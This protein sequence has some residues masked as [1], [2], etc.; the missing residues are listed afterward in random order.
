M[1]AYIIKDDESFWPM[2]KSLYHK[3]MPILMSWVWKETDAYAYITSTFR[4]DKVGEKPSVHGT[5]PCRGLDLRSWDLV[6]GIPEKIRDHVNSEWIYDP[7][8]P[9]KMVCK[10][11]K[12]HLHFQVHDN[13]RMRTDREK[14]AFLRGL[15]CGNDYVKI[16]GG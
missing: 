3:K 10:Y 13:T 15:E 14:E 7:Q 1:T 5:T 16:L 9:E 4:P 8:R 11:H 2:F 12:N 6:E